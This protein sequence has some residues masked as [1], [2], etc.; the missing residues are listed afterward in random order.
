LLGGM[1]LEFKPRALNLQSRS[2]TT[3]ATTPVL[4]ALV[5]L[6]MGSRQAGL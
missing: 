5:V 2:S 6:E 4:F 1:G 3:W